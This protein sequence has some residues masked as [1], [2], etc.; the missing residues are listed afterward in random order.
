[1]KA[2]SFA[3]TLLVVLAA[4]GTA[5]VAS[6]QKMKLDRLYKSDDWGYQIKP[7][8]EWI[9]APPDQDDKFTVGSWK[10]D[11][12][13]LEKRGM[14]EDANA[15]TYCILSIVRIQ[16]QTTTGEEPKKPDTSG[17][18]SSLRRAL[19]T[20]TSIEEWIKKEFD[21]VDEKRWTRDPLKKGKMDGEVLT[22]GHN[23]SNLTIGVFRHNGVEW[24]VVYRCHEMRRSEWADIYEKSMQT[25]KVFKDVDPDKAASK[26]KDISK[27]EGEELREALHDSI[28][29]LPGWY[30]ID[31]EHYV[32][33]TNADRRFITKLG[34]ELE[35]VRAKV[36]VPQFKPRNKKTPL[37]PVRIYATKR[38]YHAAGAPGSSAGYFSPSSGEL[39][40]Y[41]EGENQ[42][43]SASQ[44][45]CRSVMFHEGFHQYIHFAVGDVSPH[46]WF[47]EGHGDFFAGLK[48]SGNRCRTETFSWRVDALKKWLSGADLVPIRTL[49]RMP[50]SEYYSNAGLKYSQ[51]WAL[52]YYM[53]EVSRNPAHKQALTTYF[54]YLADNVAAFRAKKKKDKDGNEEDNPSMPNTIRLV[55]WEDREKV[56]KILSEAVDKA[57]AKVDLEELD[58]ELKKWIESL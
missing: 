58:V 45:D 17:L 1:M 25:F 47:N 41:A 2:R 31:T 30:A 53:R 43:T 49:I 29:G 48:V 35:T 56:E 51:G 8:K 55:D 12:A 21:G 27:L 11:T 44:D 22:F 6:A 38:E 50:Q 15:G 36:Y 24:A 32:F 18:P 13:E 46:S 7:I 9:S 5:S 26:R 20:P 37:S 4:L 54:D 57:F 42:S 33:L 3:P 10:F 39:V 19:S 40:L 16:S 34:K 28:A 52:I 23:S 14:Y